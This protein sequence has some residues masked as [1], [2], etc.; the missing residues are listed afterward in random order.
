M[1]GETLGLLCLTVRDGDC[2]IPY[3][4]LSESHKSNIGGALRE[5]LFALHARSVTVFNPGVVAAFGEA[6]RFFARKKKLTKVM[7]WPSEMDTIM[8]QGFEWQ[9]GDGDAVFT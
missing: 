1:A 2:K 9:D 3:A 7:A 5:V 6:G 8:R 4:W